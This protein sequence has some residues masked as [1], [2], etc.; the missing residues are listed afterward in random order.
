[1]VVKC[2]LRVGEGAGLGAGEDGGSDGDGAGLQDFGAGDG[3]VDCGLGWD[4]FDGALSCQLS[5]AHAS[6]FAPVSV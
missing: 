3:G 2:W 5:S 6:S 1:V 4:Y